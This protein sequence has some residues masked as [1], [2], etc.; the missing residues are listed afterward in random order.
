MEFVRAYLEVEHARFGDRLRTE[1]HM[2]PSVRGARIPTMIV[3]TLVENAM[4]HGASTVRG[5]ASVVVDAHADGDQLVVSVA[6]NGPGFS[7]SDLPAAPRARGGYGLL[8]VRQRLEGYFGPAA[9]LAV[10]PRDG[11]TVVSVALPIVRQE[12]KPHPIQEVAR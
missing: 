10:T 6:D 3:Q 1:V 4:K 8:N 5:P 11:M 2:D 9:A 7:E 12:P